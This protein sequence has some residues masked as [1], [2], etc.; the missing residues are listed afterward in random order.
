[1]RLVISLLIFRSG[2]GVQPERYVGRLHGLPNHTYEFGAHGVQVGLLA[3]LGRERFQSLSSVVLHP[4][5]TL[6][7]VRLDALTERGEQRSDH[8]SGHYYGELRLL[9]L[10]DE[11]SQDSLRYCHAADVDCH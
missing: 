7:Y 4:V 11:R 6:I 9:S 10:A 2:I 8:E 3:Q 1:M 5:E